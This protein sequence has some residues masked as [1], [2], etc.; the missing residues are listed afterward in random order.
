MV[1]GQAR[2]LRTAQRSSAKDKQKLTFNLIL[3][4]VQEGGLIMMIVNIPKSATVSIETTSTS[5]VYIKMTDDVAR[6]IHD[7]MQ[8]NA[9]KRTF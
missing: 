5:D 7:E 1:N 6:L 3:W 2:Q 9:F 8:K 4:L